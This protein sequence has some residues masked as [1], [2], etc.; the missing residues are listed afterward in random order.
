LPTLNMT[1]LTRLPDITVE[2]RDLAL[3]DGPAA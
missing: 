3:Y 2:R 1:P